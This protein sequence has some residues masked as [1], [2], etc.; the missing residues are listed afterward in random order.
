MTWRVHLTNQAIQRL[1]LL[2]GKKE[3]L[4]V[5]WSQRDRATY[6]QL[7]DG[8]E[9]GEHQH[10]AVAR[11]SDKWA[12]FVGGLVAPN[13][14][15]LPI[16]RTATFT[17][18]ST[19]DGRARLFDLGGKELVWEADG[20]DTPLEIKSG[21]L[22]FRAQAF[23]PVMGVV[24]GLDEKGKLHLYQQQIRVGTFDL[25]LKPTDED[26]LLLVISEG[27]GS[28]IAAAHTEIVLADSGGKVVKRLSVHYPV[29][30]LACSPN[31]KLLA[32]GDSETGV[33]RVYELPD[34]IPTHQRHAVD[35]IHRATPTQLI[36]EFPPQG[37]G[38]GALVISNQGEIAFTLYGMICMSTLKQMDALPRPQPLL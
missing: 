14:V 26:P 18:Y 13:G 2:A 28:I 23:D 35:L 5:A 25:K 24:G 29:G 22:P 33:I 19:I 21:T 7:S 15:H 32:T 16:I 36:A 6:F 38:P 10:Q 27:A 30:R 4:L 12:E 9:I 3:S 31:G 1:D 17:L 8:I 37:A 20:K 11:T 34:L